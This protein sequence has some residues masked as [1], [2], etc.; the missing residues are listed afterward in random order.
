MHKKGRARGGIITGVRIGIEEP[1]SVIEFREQ[2]Q[3]REIKLDD[4][5]WRIVTVYSDGNLKNITEELNEKMIE[6]D[7]RNLVL[8]GDWNAR[9]GEEGNIEDNDEDTKIR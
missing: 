2:M 3:E 7:E 9:T 1:N 6:M 8:G 5:E 4:E